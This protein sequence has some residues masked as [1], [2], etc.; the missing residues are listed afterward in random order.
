VV[1]SPVEGV[2]SKLGYPYGSGIGGASG[3]SQPYRYVQVTDS[4]QQMHRVF[5]IEPTVEMGSDI[6]EGDPIGK[7]QDLGERYEDITPHVHYE[8]KLNDGSYINPGV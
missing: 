8:I 4:N 1:C 3:S 7:A 2:V 5:Y 6:R